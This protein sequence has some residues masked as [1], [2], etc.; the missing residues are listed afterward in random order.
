MPFTVDQALRLGV[1]R[2]VLEGRRFRQL[3]RSVYVHVDVPLDLATRVAGAQLVAPRDA[4][5]TGMTALGLL[6]AGDGAERQVQLASTDAAQ[7][8]IA[9]VAVRRHVRA[10]ALCRHQGRLLVAPEVAWVEAARSLGLVPLVVAAERLLHLGHV[11]LCSL[12]AYVASSHDHGV[13]RAR[14]VLP[15]VRERVES[16][17]ETVLRL[18]LVFARLP[19][20]EANRPLRLARLRVRPDLSYEQQRVALEYDGAYHVQ[21]ADGTVDW[22]QY[23]RDLQRREALEAAGWRV[24]VVTAG[25]MRDPRAVV[26]RVDR[27]LRERGYAGPR[28]VF[29]DMWSRWFG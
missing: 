27:A 16:P 9:G 5:P 22:A 13:R 18:M 3:H 25:G 4:V 24:V 11:R 8:R 26:H 12:Q 21:K 19:E 20:P 29:D 7:R 17:R 15:L 6:D 23:N 28:P 2:R 1:S 10:P 14:R